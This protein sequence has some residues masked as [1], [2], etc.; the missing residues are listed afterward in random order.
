MKFGSVILALAAAFMLASPSSG[1]SAGREPTG[2]ALGLMREIM[3]DFFKCTVKKRTADAR[4]AVL[5]NVEAS[6]ILKEYPELLNPDCMPGR[7]NGE[8]LAMPFD[9][10]L[11]GLADALF[12]AEFKESFPSDLSDRTPLAHRVAT[13]DEDEFRKSSEF[14]KEGEAGVARLHQQ[15]KEYY[16]LSVFG[17]CVVRAEPSAVHRLLLT[18][19]SFSAERAA[20]AAAKSLL[21]PCKKQDQ[22]FNATLMRIRGSLALNFYRLAHAPRI[23]VT[24]A[25]AL[26]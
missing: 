1:H 16:F 18:K 20:F 21:E 12:Q 17:E 3:S 13:V 6:H 2:E 22:H 26:K 25:G 24:P 9:Q 7:R 23:A 19:P 10:T 14:R 15:A 8:M 11:Y 4:S 5:S